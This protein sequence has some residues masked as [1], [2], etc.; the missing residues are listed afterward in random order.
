MQTYADTEQGV[1]SFLA[2][3]AD[4]ELVPNTFRADPWVAGCWEVTFTNGLRAIVYVADHV[5]APDFEV[6]E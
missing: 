5:N 6:G 2:D 1:R 3:N 4:P